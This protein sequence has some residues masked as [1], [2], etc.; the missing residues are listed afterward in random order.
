[1]AEKRIEKLLA[2]YVP[3]PMCIINSNGKVTRAS[4]KIDEVFKY[5][6]IKDADI[7]ALTGIKFTD[8]LKSA[9]GEKNLILDRNDK[10]FKIQ[11][12]S[13][14]EEEDSSF[15][16]YFID[17]TNYETLKVKYNDEKPCICLLYTSDAADE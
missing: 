12:S 9:K 1:M 16:L 17:V 2:A 11:V 10:K 15:G 14:G 4:R 8:F 3:I 13:I 7:F 6:G 5:D